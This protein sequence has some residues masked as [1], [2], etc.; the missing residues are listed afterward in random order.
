MIDVITLISIQIKNV[1][2]RRQS[3]NVIIKNV[4]PLIIVQTNNDITIIFLY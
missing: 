3:K 4:I 2:V 1:N